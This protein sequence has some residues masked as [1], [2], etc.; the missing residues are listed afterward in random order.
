MAKGFFPPLNIM[1]QGFSNPF[2][3]PFIQG[4]S[5]SLRGRSKLGPNDVGCIPSTRFSVDG[6]KQDF[7]ADVAADFLDEALGEV[8]WVEVGRQETET[9]VN[10]VT[11]T[12]IDQVTFQ[13]PNGERTTLVFNHPEIQTT[14]PIV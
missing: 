8:Q 2:V 4:M 11:I 13:R 6:F 3:K 14:G 7:P 1:Q 10:G 9:E 5:H 12:R